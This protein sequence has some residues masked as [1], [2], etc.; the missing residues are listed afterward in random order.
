MADEKY[1]REDVFEGYEHIT[2]DINRRIA[3]YISSDEWKS[4]AEETRLEV[5][6]RLGV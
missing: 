2:E 5:K 6:N 3:T 4:L 1:A